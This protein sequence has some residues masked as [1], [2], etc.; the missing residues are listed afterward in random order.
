MMRAAQARW[1][2][3]KAAGTGERRLHGVTV[4]LLAA[5]IAH[6]FAGW[7]PVRPSPG[8]RYE[9]MFSTGHQGA[10]QPVIEEIL[11]DGRSQ[12]P[13]GTLHRVGWTEG[14]GGPSGAEAVLRWDPATGEH[15]LAFSGGSFV[16]IMDRDGWSGTVQIFRDDSLLRALPVSPGSGSVVFGEPQAWP[17]AA[18]LIPGVLVGILLTMACRP[19]H[20]D[21]HRATWLTVVLGVIHLAYWAAL[22]IGVA[23]D[24]HGYLLTTTTL[25]GGWPAYVPPGYPALLALMGGPDN[26]FIGSSITL[27]QHG[28]VIAMAAWTYRLIRRVHQP[29]IALL[30]GLT[31]GLLPPL[32]LMA[33]GIMSE[34]LA[35]FT[36]LGAFVLASTAA[37]SGRWPSAVLG[38]VLLG[39]ATITRVVPMVALGP[40]LALVF[41]L[42]WPRRR[43]RLLALTAATALVVT[44]LPLVW[45]GIRSGQPQ[46]ANSSERH[47]Y[48][49]VVKQGLLD[50]TGPAT[51]ELLDRTEGSDLTELGLPG[52]AVHPGVSD[53]EYGELSGLLGDVAREGLRRHPLRYLLFTPVAALVEL[54]LPGTLDI[55]R[56]GEAHPVAHKHLESTRPIPTTAAAL[57]LRAGFFWSIWLVWPVLLVLAIRGT[58]LGLRAPHR[59]V[60]GG[61]VCVPLLYLLASAALDEITVRHNIAISAF[62]VI[63]AALGME[64]VPRHAA[65]ASAHLPGL[66]PRRQAGAAP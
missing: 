18:L 29:V 42:P 40:A 36:M 12:H 11:V 52:V 2:E 32:L 38:G 27:L 48:N 4:A 64:S 37:E 28:L 14:R 23:P 10:G 56:W 44:A 50:S 1:R 63:L 22:P 45:F 54:A 62:V 59:H 60:V 43:P 31:V 57:R 25:L 20:S 65:S 58:V 19:W 30:G 6:A 7:H 61:L 49:R 39:I 41:L 9:L 51:R 53:L 34:T 13:D 55:P 66:P 5:V 47:L 24:S 8:G 17:V 21:R 35:A 33:Q 3:W 46:L 26:P 16:V 15:A